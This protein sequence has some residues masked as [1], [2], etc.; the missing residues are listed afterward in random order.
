MAI[1]K[2]SAEESDEK[3]QLLLDIYSYLSSEEG[4]EMLIGD[5]FQVSNIS[6]MR[7][8]SNSFSE[9]II[10]TI[11]RGQTINT[12]YLAAGETNKQVERQMLGSLKD[13]LNGDMSVEDWLLAAD[14]VRDQYVS[15][16][17]TKEE[18]YGQSETTLT[19]LETAYTVAQMYADETDAQIGICRGGGW[20]KSTNGY[21]YEGDITD[22]LLECLTP[23]KE[24]QT[25]SE[26]PYE[27]KIVVSSLTGQQI[28]D[29]LNSTEEL[30]GT[31][32]FATYF[33]AYGLDVKFAP[34]ADEG[35]K[36]QSCKT[37]DGK[38]LDPDA[39]YE[40]AYFY[41]SLP[42]ETL[43]PESALDGTWQDNFL[44]W[45]NEQGGVIKQPEMTLKLVY[46]K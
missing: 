41:G 11:N 12:L 45:L 27:G 22:S 32:G 20:G 14:E 46:D 28:L 1:N 24:P 9:G 43:E 2:S 42:D 7:L 38:E 36:V 19:R 40:V 30:S 16:E 18:S 34:W 21:F 17:L 8:T 3:K 6:D 15:G 35:S 23:D 5:N 44:T 39:V 37:A 13:M 26:D 4:Q 25:D 29:I 10:D 31:K 33:V